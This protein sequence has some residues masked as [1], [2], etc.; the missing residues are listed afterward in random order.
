MTHRMNVKLAE[1]PVI[2]AEDN[3]VYN[4]PYLMK[5][6]TLILTNDTNIRDSRDNHMWFG[7]AIFTISRHVNHFPLDLTFSYSSNL[8]EIRILFRASRAGKHEY[9]LSL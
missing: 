4:S 3:Q 2:C 5:D 1:G 6:E 9:D 8:A 7:R